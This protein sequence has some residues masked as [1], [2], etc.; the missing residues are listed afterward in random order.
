LFCKKTFSTPAFPPPAKAGITHLLRPF[1]QQD[2]FDSLKN[3]G[4]VER[5][6]KMFDIEEIE[7]QL[8]LRVFNGRTVLILDLRPSGK[9]RTD[10][11]PLR[12]EIQAGVQQFAE[13]RLL[14]PWTHQAHGA[15][16]NVEELR[17][18]VQSIF[19]DERSN[20]GDAAITVS[21]PA[22]TALFSILTHGT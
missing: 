15:A 4:Q 21:R 1:T 11:V 7:L 19:A 14:R 3:D 18:F 22:R 12:K 17:Q 9:P 8:P 2:H 16:Q 20:P 5:D 6:R 13:I 10:C